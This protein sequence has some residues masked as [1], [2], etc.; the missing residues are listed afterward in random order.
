MAVKHFL[1]LLALLPATTLVAATTKSWL[2]V[3][4]QATDQ[5]I[6]P[7]QTGPTPALHQLQ[8]KIEDEQSPGLFQCSAEWANADIPR[9]PAACSPVEGNDNQNV[10]FSSAVA[11]YESASAGFQVDITERDI[12]A[13]VVF[14]YN[15]SIVETA[16]SD[17]ENCTLTPLQ[18]APTVFFA[19]CDWP[20]LDEFPTA[21]TES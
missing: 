17:G 14:Q 6:D 4:L 1:S 3:D 20:P 16:G 19:S 10:T 5:P 21:V 13:D 12:V 8:F 2:V 15:G 11:S 18:N 7:T 9:S